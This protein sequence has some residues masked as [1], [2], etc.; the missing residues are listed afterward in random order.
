MPDLIFTV[1]R[2]H[3]HVA[4]RVRCDSEGCEIVNKWID[5]TGMSGSE[6][7]SKMIKFADQYA[8]L[9]EGNV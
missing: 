2:S 4:N 8:R 5:Q 7:F 9:M 3:Q 6:I 1:C